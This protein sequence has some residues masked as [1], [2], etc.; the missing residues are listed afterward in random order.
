MFLWSNVIWIVI[1]TYDSKLIF[2]PQKYELIEKISPKWRELQNLRD[3]LRVKGRRNKP[4][5]Y[6]FDIVALAMVWHFMATLLVKVVPGVAYISQV[7]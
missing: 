2:N 3:F 1:R 7:P 5:S 4:Q 6:L